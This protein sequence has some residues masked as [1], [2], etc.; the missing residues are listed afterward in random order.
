MQWLHLAA[1]TAPAAVVAAAVVLILSGVVRCDALLGAQV[2]GH[3]L[4]LLLILLLGHLIVVVQLQLVLLLGGQGKVTIP[5][6]QH[7]GGGRLWGHG[8]QGRAQCGGRGQ[9]ELGPQQSTRVEQ[10]IVQKGQIYGGNYKETRS[11][12]Y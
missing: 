3:V 8:G 11:V 12:G 10:W 7:H 6:T 5:L 1:R 4:V 2:E 9:E